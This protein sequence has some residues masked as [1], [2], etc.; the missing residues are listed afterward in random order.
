M[1]WFH[2]NTSIPSTTV[3]RDISGGHDLL[4]CCLQD[5]P[6]D[7]AATDDADAR[8]CAVECGES[9]KKPSFANMHGF[10]RLVHTVSQF[11][12]PVFMSRKSGASTNFG[13]T[14]GPSYPLVRRHDSWTKFVRC[15]QA[16]ARFAS[17][18]V[19]ENEQGD[20]LAIKIYSN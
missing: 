12:P 19:R 15:D 10:S 20:G 6:M 13:T 3:L 1:R 17:D 18:F 2:D 7:F 5:K 16:I 8:S 14:F 4:Y 11:S 9:Q